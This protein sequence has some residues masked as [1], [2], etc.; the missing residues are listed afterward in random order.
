MERI[1][2]YFFS[3]ELPSMSFLKNP[4]DF[5][6]HFFRSNPFTGNFSSGFLVKNKNA[7]INFDFEQKVVQFLQLI[8]KGKL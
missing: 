6:F 4:D 7:D 2:Q 1:F 5:L 8:F 3:P